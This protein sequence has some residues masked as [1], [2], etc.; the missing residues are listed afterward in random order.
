MQAEL[1]RIKDLIAWNGFPKIIGNAI[2]NNKL[3]GL[4]GNNIKNTTNSNLDIIW[5]KIP[6]IG[7]KEDQLLKSLKTSF[8]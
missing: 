5:I 7:D 8:Y 6:Y 4:K 2:V 1:T 3:K